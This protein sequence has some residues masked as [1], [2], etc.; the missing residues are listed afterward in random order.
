[1][2]VIACND[3]LYVEKINVARIWDFIFLILLN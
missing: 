1:M 3:D 2:Y